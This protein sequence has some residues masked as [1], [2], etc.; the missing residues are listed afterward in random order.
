MRIPVPFGGLIVLILLLAGLTVGYAL[1]A[2]GYRSRP[3]NTVRARAG[4]AVL[5]GIAALI[6]VSIG[7]EELFGVQEW[8]PFPLRGET[9]VGTWRDGGDRL[10]LRADSTY[11]LVASHHPI[12]GV[13]SAAGRWSLDDWNLRLD[14]ALGRH[15][16]SLRVVVARGEYRIMP[17]VGDPDE[18]DGRLA[19]RRI[20]SA[21]AP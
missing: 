5:G 4:M 17:A 3:R 9:L 16:A 10:D 6:L 14:D 18:W 7:V 8:N 19:Y 21:K 11:T 15:A 20:P 12:Y 2:S 1:I 13:T